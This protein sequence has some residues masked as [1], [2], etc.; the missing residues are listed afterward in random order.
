MSVTRLTTSW[1]GYDLG[2]GAL[3][4]WDGAQFRPLQAAAGYAPAAHSHAIG[5]VTGLQAALDGKLSAA[6]TL[7]G[8]NTTADATNRLAVK[9]NAALFSHDDVT[10]GTGD[11]RI[12]VDKSAAAKDAAFVFQDAA[13]T[14]ALFGLLGDD[15]FTIK[16]SPDGAAFR[17]ALS[18]D[19]STGH[20]GLNGFAADVNNALGVKGTAFLFD[21]E[22]DHCRFTF[23][24]TASAN[25]VALTFQTGYSARALVGLLGDDNFTFKVSADGSSYKTGFT[26]DK[27]TGAVDH[28]QGAKFSAY[29]NF[30]QNYVAGAWR[31]LLFNNL[32]HNDQNAATI[33]ANVLTFTAP[34]AGHYLF[35]LAATFETTGGAAPTKMQ[36]GLSVNGAAPNSDTI[37]TAGDAAITDQKTQVAATALLK[38]A[39]SDTVAAKIFF[40]TNDGR[41]LASENSFW[42]ARIS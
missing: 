12:A 24:K 32:R 30:G 8:V 21:A 28:A 33:A 38:L 25:D 39:A 13:S 15:N 11:M 19:K 36:V 6:P 31:D 26:I 2:S 18:V 22:T 14:R 42:G 17:Q 41:V 34:T 10:P 40:T 35:G 16:V 3:W 4:F 23:N 29:L 5:D 7:L 1:L 20:V 27:S 37:G 9:S